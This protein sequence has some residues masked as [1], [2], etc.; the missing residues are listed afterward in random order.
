MNSGRIGV[1]G[2]SFYCGSGSNVPCQ[3]ALKSDIPSVT[4]YV[5]P[6]TKQCNYAYTHPTTKQCTG[7]DAGTLNGKNASQIISEAS[8]ASPIKCI[9]NFS[10]TYSITDSSNYEDKI[11]S[12]DGALAKIFNAGAGLLYTKMSIVSYSNGSFSGTVSYNLES[13]KA[14]PNTGDTYVISSY[15]GLS[16]A[17]YSKTMANIGLYSNHSSIKTLNNWS[18]ILQA[19][20]GID[21]S[22]R[23]VNEKPSV[24][25]NT[26]VKIDIYMYVL[27]G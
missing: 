9:V 27:T 22:I 12:G 5:H 16:T 7:G 23:C 26:S 25:I 11:I 10:K 15:F 17:N 6:S 21:F 20:D 3:L 18:N 24:P 2:N 13:D 1:S 4:P 19:G 14:S 8:A